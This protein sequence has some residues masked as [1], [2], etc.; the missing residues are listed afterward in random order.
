M[1]ETNS[2][3]KNKLLKE[4]QSSKVIDYYSSGYA[5][6]LFKIF[7]NKKELCFVEKK[8]QECILCKNK[9]ECIVE[10]YYQFL[11]IL[12]NKCKENLSTECI[13]KKSDHGFLTTKIKY[14]I[15]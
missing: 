7:S 4:L 1:N 3:K 13:C 9:F 15:K 14:I 6:E 8:I 5:C 11:L 2:K 10:P 12:I